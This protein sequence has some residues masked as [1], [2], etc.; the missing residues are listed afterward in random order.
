MSRSRS[1]CK[2]MEVLPSELEEVISVTLAMCANWRSSG[3]ATEEAMISALAPGKAGA[4][5]DGGEI[6]FRKRRDG[7]DVEGHGASQGHGDGQQRGGDGTVDEWRGDV[8]GCQLPSAG[9]GPGRAAAE[10]HSAVVAPGFLPPK[11]SP[12][13]SKKM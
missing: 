3:V 6:D 7:Q 13:R 2:V 10:W 9:F 8:H 1:N 12:R 4:H 11:R 5:G